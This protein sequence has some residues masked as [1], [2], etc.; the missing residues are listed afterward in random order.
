MP[1]VIAQGSEGSFLVAPETGLMIWTLLAFAITLFILRKWAFPQIADALD[2]RRRRIEESI[3]TAERPRREADELLSEYRERLKE[4]REQADD[5]VTRARK[6]GER[7]EEKKKEEARK[8]Y[9]EMIEQAKRDIEAERRKAVQDLRREGADQTVIATEKVTRK[10]LDDDDHRRLV[11]EALDEA[12]FESLAGGQ[13][14][15]G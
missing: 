9:E 4:A 15:N 2:R 14:S 1:L 10:S 13:S 8:E 3:D 12:D 6:N 5:I 11:E 7:H